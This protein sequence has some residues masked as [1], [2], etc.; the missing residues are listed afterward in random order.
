MLASGLDKHL[1]LFQ[2]DGL[3]N[4]KLQTVFFEDCPV[5]KAAFC[6]G[7]SSVLCAGR[8]PHFYMYN[9]DAGRID[10]IQGMLGR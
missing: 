7:G 8:R 2:V 10:R 5:T 9:V 6:L 1:R 4:P 3:R